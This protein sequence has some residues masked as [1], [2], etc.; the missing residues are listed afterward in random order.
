MISKDPNRSHAHHTFIC[1]PYLRKSR[2]RLFYVIVH[3]KREWFSPAASTNIVLIL[4]AP[5]CLGFGPRLTLRLITLLTYD[6]VLRSILLAGETFEYA[7]NGISF[8]FFKHYAGFPYDLQT[9]QSRIARA[10][11]GRKGSGF[12]LIGDE[13]ISARVFAKVFLQSGATRASC[14]SMSR[15]RER[16]RERLSEK[17]F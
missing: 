11:V 13:S 9:S 14:N 2:F 16:E 8:F 6:F 15:E 4:T 10:D 1:M 3:W 7:F 12:Y 17:F 5:T